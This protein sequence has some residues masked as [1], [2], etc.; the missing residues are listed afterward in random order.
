MPSR[1][2]RDNGEPRITRILSQEETEITEIP[3]AD[4]ADLNGSILG[5]RANADPARAA[6]SEGILGVANFKDCFGGRQIQP[7]KEACSTSFPSLRI[8]RL[9]L[10]YP[11]FSFA[12]NSC[13]FAYLADKLF[14]YAR[15]ESRRP[16]RFCPMPSSAK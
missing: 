11:R 16:V 3:T 2:G 13:F 9:N 15:L 1:A 12:F 10:R 4:Y 6:R 7:S 14:G 5:E 8:I